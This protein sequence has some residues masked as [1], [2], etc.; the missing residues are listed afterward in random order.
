ML[1][2]ACLNGKLEKTD[3]VCTVVDQLQ[4]WSEILVWDYHDQI[5]LGV[6]EELELGAFRLH[7]N[8]QTTRPHCLSFTDSVHICKFALSGSTGFC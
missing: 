5:Q 3:F 8:A 1:A 4:A 7:S 2:T 6:R